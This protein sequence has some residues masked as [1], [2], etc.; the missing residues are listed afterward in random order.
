MKQCILYSNFSLD[1]K[2]NLRLYGNKSEI[3]TSQVRK[4]RVVGIISYTILVQNNV[5]LSRE[6]I[7]FLIN[8]G[9][10]NFSSKYL[11]SQGNYCKYEDSTQLEE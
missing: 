7:Y 4:H 5:L 6:E 11:A 10:E 2:G 8:G 1:E 3:H 9:C